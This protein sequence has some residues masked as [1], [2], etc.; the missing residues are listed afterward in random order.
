MRL[1][2]VPPKT[3]AQEPEK[4]VRISWE[5]GSN[6]TIHFFAID[7]NGERICYGNI[8]EL[9]LSEGIWRF[10]G[11]NPSLGFPLDDMGRIKTN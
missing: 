5:A 9:S 6:G 3:Q 11:L 8:V 2:I 10:D 4:V 1:E 7:E